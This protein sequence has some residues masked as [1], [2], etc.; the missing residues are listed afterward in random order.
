M[1]CVSGKLNE[2]QILVA[3]HNLNKAHVLKAS[4]PLMISPSLQKKAIRRIVEWFALEGI[5]KII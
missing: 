3:P 4:S 5:L 2:G 1:D